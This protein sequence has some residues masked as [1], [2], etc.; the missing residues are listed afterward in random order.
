MKA[1]YDIASNDAFVDG[2]TDNTKERVA[3]AYLTIL[4]QVGM[5]DLFNSQ[6]KPLKAQPQDY[7]YYL[8]QG[9]DWFLEA[10][11]L[12]SFEIDNIKSVVL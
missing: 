3:S 7:A 1:F 8:K 10:C 5:L 11:L 9:E 4:R 2:W 12:Q 6:L